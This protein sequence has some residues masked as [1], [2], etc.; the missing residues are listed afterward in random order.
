[1]KCGWVE[2]GVLLNFPV[3][4]AKEG[5]WKEQKG[6]KIVVEVITWSRD[7][8]MRCHSELWCAVCSDV[9]W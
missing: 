6:V 2:C 1:M 3:T 7:Q 4:T 8:S 9:V 5:E